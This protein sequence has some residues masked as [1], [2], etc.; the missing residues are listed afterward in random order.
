MP[1]P[2]VDYLADAL[3]VDLDEMGCSRVILLGSQTDMA[4]GGLRTALA[5]R[6]KLVLVPPESTRAWIASLAN[7]DDGELPH[8]QTERLRL[9]LEDGAEHGVQAIVTTSERLGSIVRSCGLSIPTL[10]R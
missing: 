3:R 5:R 9:L 4:D 6:G 10:V 7:M 8:D 2:P 1:Q